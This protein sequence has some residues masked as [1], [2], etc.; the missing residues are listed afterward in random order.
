[1]PLYSFVHVNLGTGQYLL[2]SWD[3]CFLN[4]QCEKSLCP[5]LR[6]KKPNYPIS[7]EVEKSWSSMIIL[8]TKSMCPIA[9]CI[10]PNPQ[11]ILTGTLLRAV[12]HSIIGFLF[13]I[14]PNLIKMNFKVTSWSSF[15]SVWINIINL[16]AQIYWLHFFILW[17]K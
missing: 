10:G 9:F 5:I 8:A 2:G 15:I 13:E 16:T 7:A 6:E 3:R 17:Y 4:F 1:M 14:T 12:N 11:W